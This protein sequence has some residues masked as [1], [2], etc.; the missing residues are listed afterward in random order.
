[1]KPP[2]AAGRDIA[3]TLK[4]AACSAIRFVHGGQVYYLTGSMQ[5][6]TIASQVQ[7]VTAAS[8]AAAVGNG[9]VFSTT[10]FTPPDT[11]C[12]TLVTQAPSQVESIAT[13]DLSTLGLVPPFH[14]EGS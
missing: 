11:C 14:V 1:L 7:F 9:S 6:R 5:T 4:V 12:E 3:K 13:F 2:I 8:C 10:S